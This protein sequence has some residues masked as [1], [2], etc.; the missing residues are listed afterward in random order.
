MTG[1][2][3]STNDGVRRAGKKLAEHVETVIVTLGDRGVFCPQF[4][5]DIVPAYV[6][7]T[8]DTTGAGD[9]FAGVLAAYLARGYGL[10]EAVDLA[11][12]G[13]A[14]STCKFGTSPSMPTQAE[15]EKAAAS[16]LERRA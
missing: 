8:I 11:Q 15:I 13:A 14:L 12:V 2:D 5:D 9:A 16:G 6:V 7:D 4:G 1:T 3:C 10:A